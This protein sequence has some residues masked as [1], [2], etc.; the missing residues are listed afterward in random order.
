MNQYFIYIATNNSGTLYIGVTNDLNRRMHE[1]K[2]GNGSEFTSKY[3]VDILIYF[4]ETS[5]VEDA[6]LR[7]KQL[8]GWRR[9]KKISL[10]N[11]FNPQWND[12]SIDVSTS[13]NMT[14]T[15]GKII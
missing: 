3:N 8:K 9:S 2:S 5:S 15:S 6:I 1:H 11:A 7:E 14:G 13:L 4:E 12:L 10:I